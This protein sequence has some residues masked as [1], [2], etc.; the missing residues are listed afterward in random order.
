MIARTR[1]RATM[2]SETRGLHGGHLQAVL[3]AEALKFFGP[4]TRDVVAD[5]QA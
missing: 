4:L 5:Q 2:L 3:V 1:V